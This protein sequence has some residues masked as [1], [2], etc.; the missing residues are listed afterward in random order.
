MNLNDD[1]KKLLAGIALSLFVMLLASLAN[2]PVE[3]PIENYWYDDIVDDSSDE[4]ED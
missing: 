4:S 3:P 2:P 1:Q